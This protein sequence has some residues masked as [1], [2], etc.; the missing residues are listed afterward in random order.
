MGEL[1]WVSVLGE[2]KA[3]LNRRSGWPGTVSERFLS[4]T[5]ASDE[6]EKVQEAHP[7]ADQTSSLFVTRRMTSSVKFEVE[8]P[9]VRSGVV[10]PSITVSKTD[11]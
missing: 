8:S 3:V 7:S 4:P 2:V 11:S 6:I 9:P 1:G 5:R 10:L